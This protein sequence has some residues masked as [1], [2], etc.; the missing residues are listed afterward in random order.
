MNRMRPF[1]VTAFFM[2]LSMGCS[3]SSHNPVLPT[4]QGADH[5]LTGGTAE[6]P[7]GQEYI[8]GYYSLSFD[9]ENRKVEVVPCRSSEF[10]L[11]VVKFLNNDP[12][13]LQV[14]FN[15]TTPGTGYVD[16]NLD[17]TIKHPLSD[18]AYDGYDVRGVFIGNG[19]KGL[20]YDNTL[21]YSTAGTDQLLLNADGYTRWF[22]P[23]E[24][25]VPK[26]FGYVPGKLATKGY[27]GTARLNPYKYFGEGLGETDSLWDY[28]TSGN[29]NTGYFLA[30]TSNTRNYIIRFPTP[31]P[32]IKF[33]Y[34]VTANWSGTD[35]ASHPSH[36]LEAVGIKLEDNSTLYYVD[37]THKGGDLRLDIS[38]FD[39]DAELDGGV[40]NDY[41]VY[42]EGSV[43]STLYHLTESEMTPTA[44]GTHWF[45]Y[46]V[47]IQA[48][49]ITG[50]EGNEMWVVVEDSNADYTNPLG[51]PNTADGDH[52]AAC[53]RLP[54]TVADSQPAW[55]QVNT[56]NGGENWQ[57]GL[58]YDIT[59]DADPSIA[60]VKIELSLD[61][62]ASYPQVFNTSTPNDGIFAWGPILE[63]VG[64]HCRIRISDT[65]N[66]AVNDA[67]DADFTVYLPTI[68]VTSP[69]GGEIWQ[70]GSTHN[71]TWDVDP[72]IANVKIALSLDSGASYPQEIV[73][74]TPNDGTFAWDPIPWEAASDHCRVR[75]SD[76]DNWL[77]EDESDG[78]FV[79]YQPW[80]QVL[81][82]NGGENWQVGSSHEI[83]WECSETGGTVS[84]AYSKDNFGSDIHVIIPDSPNDGS[85]MWDSI[86]SDLSSNVKV[87]VSLNGSSPV[88]EDASDDYFSI[89]PPPSITVLT[90]NGGEVLKAG[91]SFEITWTSINVSEWMNI[92]YSKD[93]FLS[94]VN[95]IVSGTDNDSS[96]M[97][98]PIPLDPSDTVRI[99]VES[100]PDPDIYDISDADFTLTDSGWART[101]GGSSDDYGQSAAVDGSGNTYVTGYFK[102]TADF[103]PDAAGVDSHT[104]IGVEDIFLSKLD[105]SGDFQWAR[106]WGGS[107][108]DEGRGVAV[109]VSGNVYVTG[110]FYEIVDF[111]PAAAGI[112]NHTSNGCDDVLLSKFDSSG[113]FLWARTWGGTGHDQAYG[114]A[115]DKSGHTYVTGH[116][117]GMVDFDPGTGV[118]SHTSKGLTDVFL[119][120]F[121]SSGNFLWADTWGG[122]DYDH[123]SGVAVDPYNNAYVIGG[124]QGIVDFD[125]GS[126]IENHTSNG[127]YDI[128]LSK[129]DPTG[130]YSGAVTWGGSD[131]DWPCGVAVD[132]WS[133]A[134][135]TGYFNGTV[136]FGGDSHTSN[137]YV[138]VFLSKFGSSPLYFKWTRTWGGSGSDAGYGVAVDVL[139]DVYVTGNFQGTDVDFDPAGGIDNH[140]SNG[141]VDAFLSQ[142][143][144]SGY[145]NWARTWGGT[146]NDYSLAVA[147]DGSGNAYVTGYFFGTDVDFDPGTGVDNHTSNGNNDAFLSKFLP[148]GNW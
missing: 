29:A 139:G 106:T 107:G 62:G 37:N 133:N 77:V 42:V 69:N 53:F 35:P 4:D 129:I 80:M 90:P 127:S 22:N 114:V 13:G 135:V 126:E 3:G 111:D 10:T 38:V 27:T 2:A 88:I 15:G 31:T 141:G 84:I 120:K 61:S 24:F 119:S 67:S 145:F 130:S 75:I 39:W 19:S 134:Y 144:S 32:G 68:H 92:Y 123:S 1:L 85:Y 86:P 60:N 44:S 54:V 132:V 16:V 100:S 110:L 52:I 97:W 41:A 56:P 105:S 47:E 102:G 49:N 89:V 57:V 91:H 109:D 83:T 112:E 63:Q 99:K 43:L 40:M 117:E 125:P 147:A 140:T 48:D 142:F 108:L 118:D 7:L 65:A 55:V 28:L 113:N 33:G 8:W 122:S 116:L 93:G 74:S 59:W 98:D 30:G 104:S 95:L 12:L 71:I 46:H 87:R 11:N 17:V 115:T 94:D 103:D 23:T 101:W 146:L 6:S 124:F 76:V 143:D 21:K 45:T 82:P 81:S 26:I 25:A 96:Y 148:D 70:V 58:F 5:Q 50:T 79:V 64:D 131:Y 14:D 20:K 128:F 73:A 72:S 121:D 51:V 137:G 18:H 138:D 136:D 78:D 66:A 36:A 9:L 34:V